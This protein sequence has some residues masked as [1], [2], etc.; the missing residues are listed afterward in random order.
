MN[1]QNLEKNIKNNVLEIVRG[2]HVHI[3]SKFYFI[4]HLIITIL[5]AV[6]SLS[7][8]AFIISF[9]FFSIHES[10]EQ[11]LLGFGSQGILTFLLLF[12]WTALALDIIFLLLLEWLIQGFK[13]GYRISLL[14][15]FLSVFVCSTIVG[16]LVNITPV[17]KTLLKLA[18]GGNLPIIGEMYESLHDSHTDQGVFRGNVVSI[19]GNEIIIMRNDRDHDS[20]EIERTITLPPNSP[21]LN[22]GDSVYIFGSSTGQ[23]VGVMGIQKFPAEQ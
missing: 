22:I 4:A 9:V 18:D 16:L 8:S 3:R 1:E 19:Q 14:T 12:P 6:L 15:I 7:I 13:F 5:V 17:H 11:F 23:T 2:G 10:G 21:V 20:D